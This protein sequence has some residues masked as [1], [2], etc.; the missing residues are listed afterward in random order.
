MNN[1]FLKVFILVIL[2]AFLCNPARAENFTI[3]PDHSQI[4]FHLSYLKV[5]RIQGAFES[6]RGQVQLDSNNRPISAEIILDAS[7]INTND[8]KRDHHLKKEDF[9][10]T[11]RHP[12][13]HFRSSSIEKGS[14]PNRYL[15]RG[16]LLF[17]E[18]EYSQ[19]FEA[20]LLGIE[21]DPWG[22]WSHFYE[23]QGVLDRQ[24]LGLQW[25][26]L[27]DSGE[28]LLGDEIYVEGRLQLQPQGDETPFSTHMVPGPRAG[29]GMTESTPAQEKEERPVVNPSLSS[30]KPEERIIVRTE[31][32]QKRPLWAMTVIGL[33]S[34]S[35]L[36][37]LS[38]HGRK[39][40]QSHIEDDSLKIHL[41]DLFLIFI[42]L[43][44]AIAL[45]FT[46]R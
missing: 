44:F 29:Q 20:T 42:T 31:P 41:F 37:L 1:N 13:I 24:E 17:Q 12:H 33:F 28:L 25:N 11:A 34:F 38:I 3:N 40:V 23:F 8:R 18:R 27:L 32:A 39:F 21:Q 30:N 9:F 45:D 7:S 10:W 4:F 16:T 2:Q 46:F 15:I 22:K 36:I 19:T 5:S 6:F 43:G 26:R 35:G 14:A